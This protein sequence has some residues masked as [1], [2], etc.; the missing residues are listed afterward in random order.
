MTTTLN[1][2]SILFP[3]EWVGEIKSCRAEW[4][5]GKSGVVLGFI[6]FNAQGQ[7]IWHEG[8]FLEF[9]PAESMSFVREKYGLPFKTFVRDN[10]VGV[11]WMTEKEGQKTYIAESVQALQLIKH[12]IA[13]FSRVTSFG[14]SDSLGIFLDVDEF[15]IMVKRD[16]AS[17]ILLIETDRFV[18]KPLG[19][20]AVSAL[21]EFL[22]NY[23]LS[24]KSEHGDLQPLDFS[25]ADLVY[26]SSLT[27]QDFI[28]F[29]VGDVVKYVPNHAA[30]END[31]V[32]EIGKV[33][34]V[35]GEIGKQKV[36]VKYGNGDTGQ[37]TPT[38]NLV[39]LS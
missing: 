1:E 38:K 6:P 26:L 16:P 14:Y 13:S 8:K 29:S 35:E 39:L 3:P 15:R 28:G 25:R 17:A 18:F 36:W 23:F 9:F 19:E 7:R 10:M 31:L 34:S 12:E 4:R 2:F 22:R 33:S 30:D 20:Y 21:L 27:G 32:C 37:L 24:E 11:R 5:D